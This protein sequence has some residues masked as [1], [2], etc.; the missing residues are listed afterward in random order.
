M[1]L[2]LTILWQNKVKNMKRLSTK[3]FFI[4]GRRLNEDSLTVKL[5][6][7]MYTRLIVAAKTETQHANQEEMEQIYKIN[8][9]SQM[10]LKNHIKDHIYFIYPTGTRARV[11]DHS[12]YKVLTESVNYLRKFD[13]VIFLSVDGNCMFPLP[14]I[15]MDSEPVVKD[16]IILQF[17]KAFHVKELI[18]KAQEEFEQKKE[19]E[20]E[21]FKTFLASKIEDYIYGQKRTL[22]WKEDWVAVY[23]HYINKFEKS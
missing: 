13:Q 9:A 10:Y 17:S 3:S 5:F 8:Y 12:T 1:L 14:N 23:E 15:G 18:Q 20:Q 11:W 2:F 6:A 7:E 21:N 22:P 19:N 16:K 4:A